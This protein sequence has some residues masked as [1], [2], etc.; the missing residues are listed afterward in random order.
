MHTPAGPPQKPEAR[1]PSPGLLQPV[2]AAAQ[3]ARRAPSS[4]CYPPLPTCRETTTTCPRCF[5]Q[6]LGSDLGSQFFP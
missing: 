6:V 2:L 3:P 5:R 4:S 1:V